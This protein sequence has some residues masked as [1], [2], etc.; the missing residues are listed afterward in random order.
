MDVRIRGLSNARDLVDAEQTGLDM[1]G[2]VRGLFPI[3]RS[4]TGDEVRRSLAKL[5]AWLPLKTQEIATGTKVFD[6]TGP[7]EWNL[8]DAHVK[9][10]RRR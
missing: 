3:C 9:D 6:W 8:R 4:I 5:G 1:F 2:M 10:G 7:R